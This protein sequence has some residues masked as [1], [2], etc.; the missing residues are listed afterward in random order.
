MHVFAEIRSVTPIGV[1]AR[2]SIAKHADTVYQRVLIFQ[3]LG[4]LDCT[5]RHI[6]IPATVM[7]R[8][9]VSEENNDLLRIVAPAMLGR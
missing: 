3:I 2:V 6:G 1:N 5:V 7:I 9:T 8:L 4:F